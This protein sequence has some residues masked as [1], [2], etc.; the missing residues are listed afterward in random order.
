MTKIAAKKSSL[1]SQKLTDRPWEALPPELAAVLRED[2][3]A[4][5]EEIIEEIRTAVPAY[6]RPLEGAFGQAIRTGVERALW[7]FLDDVEGK[8]R[9]ETG[10]RDIYALL[11]RGEVRQGRS[12]EA[13]LAAYRIGARVS[14]R[15]ASAVGRE[16]GFDAETLSLLAEAFFAYIDELSARSAQGFAE[17]QSAAAGES[18]RRRRALLGLLIQVPPADAASIE[19]AARD[20]AWELPQTLAALVWADDSEQAVGRRLPLGSLAAPLGEGLVCALVPD[21]DGPGRRAELEQALGHRRAALGPVTAAAEVW[22]SARRARDLHRLLADEV[23]D[24]QLAVADEHLAE[25]VVHGDTGLAEEL[26]AKRLEPLA[27]RSPNSRARL[28]ETLS[29]WLDHQG[30]VPQVAEVLQVHPQTVRYRMAQLRELFGERLEDPDA[31]FELALAVRARA[32][33]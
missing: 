33:R 17:E 2:V 5:V 19:A 25:L 28:L 27:G 13:L 23:I 4:T 9:E 24:G 15:R 10:D 12:M 30:N 16:A 7:E 31:R 18:A 14:W 1:R 11:G 26:A 8:P 22:Q 32:A 20:A 3:P 6:A 29:A 21:A